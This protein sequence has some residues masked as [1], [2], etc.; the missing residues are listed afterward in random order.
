M[1]HG[2]TDVNAS[3]HSVLINYQYVM[4]NQCLENMGVGLLHAC[5]SNLNKWLQI[6]VEL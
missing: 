5:I 1:S 6:P 3:L 4:L 2:N